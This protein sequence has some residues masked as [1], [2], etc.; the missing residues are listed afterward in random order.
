MKKQ[1]LAL[2]LML[3]ML[4]GM[5]PMHVFAGTAGLQGQS[6]QNTNLA[7]GTVNKSGTADPAVLAAYTADSGS[8]AIA[9]NGTL[10]SGEGWLLQGH[11][12]SG[13]N[14]VG[15]F[16][17]QWNKNHLFLAIKRTSAQDTITLKINGKTVDVSAL[18]ANASVNKAMAE[19]KIPMSQLG[20]GNISGYNTLVALELSLSSGGRYQGNLKL[21][22]V[23]WWKA[24]NVE[25]TFSSAGYGV[26]PMR[27]LDVSEAKKGG[28]VGGK[29]ITNGLQLWDKYNPTS[30]A[31]NQIGT[32]IET[33]ILTASQ[34]S[35]HDQTYYYS[36]DF[37]AD[38][39]PV[40]DLAPSLGG[41]TYSQ[42]FSNFGFSWQ[43]G[44]N[45]TNDS[46]GDSWADVVMGG[47]VNT[48]D[49]LYLNISGDF[50]SALKL[51]KKVGDTFTVGLAWHKNGDVSVY[52]DGVE[53]GYFTGKTRNLKNVVTDGIRFFC[54]RDE[55]NAFDSSDDS[56][57]ISVTSIAIG[58]ALPESPVEALRF[59]DIRN[60]NASAEA[61]TSDLVLPTVLN[62]DSVFGGLNVTWESSHPAVISAS[63][64]VT[65]PASGA[66]KVTLTAKDSVG[67]QKNLDVIVLGNTYSSVRVLVVEGD[68]NPA[69]GSAKKY[70]GGIFHFDSNNNSLVYDQVNA[71]KTNV[72]KL[73]DIDEVSRLNR[74]SISI[75]TSNDNRKYTRLEDNFKLLHSGNSW[76]LYDFEANARYIKVNY[77]LWDTEESDFANVMN[78]A[79]G[80]II[81]AYYEDVFGANYGTFSEKSVTVTNTTTKK[82]QD[83]PWKIAG[84]SLGINDLAKVRVKLSNRYLYHYTDGKD[85]YVRIPDLEKNES[86]TL[87]ILH[88]N[89]GAMDISNK[90]AV[91]EVTYGTKEMYAGDTGN[92]YLYALKAGT[93]LRNGT[94]LTKDVVLYNNGFTFQLSDDGGYTWETS[95]SYKTS[96]FSGDSPHAHGGYIFDNGRLYWRTQ[97]YKGT[98]AGQIII[99]YSDDGGKTWVNPVLLNKPTVGGH[100]FAHLDSYANGVALSSRDGDGPKVDYIFSVGGED[101]NKLWGNVFVI[102]T[103]GGK[104]WKFGNTFLS[105]PSEQGMEGGLTEA[106]LLENESGELVWYCRYQTNKVVTFATS[107]SKDSGLSWTTPTSSTVYGTNTQPVL[108]KI[109][110]DPLFVWGGNNAF[111]GHTFNRMPLS[112]AVSYDGL[113]TFRNIQNAFSKTFLENYTQTE[114]GAFITNPSVAK[115][116]DDLLIAYYTIYPGYKVF[117]RLT[118][119]ENWFY[120]T[121]GAYDSF[122]GQNTKYEGWITYSGG[123][124]I[125]NNASAGKYALEIA[126]NGLV[127]RSI[128]YLQNGTVSLDVYADGQSTF[129]I[130][131]QSAFTPVIRKCAPISLTVKGNALY[132]NGYDIGVKLN[133]GWN[134]IKINLG[135]AKN[136]PTASVCVNNGVTL[137]L[138]ANVAVGDYICYIAVTTGDASLRIDEVLV[139]SS[140][141]AVNYDGEMKDVD[142]KINTQP[143]AQTA[144]EGNK[145]TFSVKATGNGLTYQWYVNEG[146]GWKVIP[147]GTSASY[148]TDVLKTSN[149]GHQY[150]CLVWDRNENSVESSAVSLNV[151]SCSHVANKDDGNCTTDITCSLCGA[152]MTEG[153]KAHTE[154]IVNAKDATTTKKGYTGDKVCSVCG[155]VIEKGK[156]I[157]IL[158]TIPTV[159]N[160]PTTAPGKPSQ[161]GTP[162]TTP[163]ATTDPS[164][165]TTTPGATTDPSSP[166]TTPGAT[167]DP[168]NPTTTPG[169]TTGP[170]NPTANPS[171]P[172]DPSNP[173]NPVDPSSPSEPDAT[174]SP[175]VNDE[176]GAPKQGSIV[177]YIVIGAVALLGAAAG[178]VFYFWKKRSSK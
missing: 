151:K 159:P 74:E 163:G 48:K 133:A 52:I 79:D 118:D 166:T 23:N 31:T 146:S 58:A 112:I 175:D 90:E 26:H 127:S 110:G 56:F 121:K 75:W 36:F 119:F 60:A 50:S 13:D 10:G 117:T 101:Q 176:P 82:L 87:K 39:M 152:V 45:T 15:S 172:T 24:S 94:T 72:I 148:T 43:M 138:N 114:L 139:Q 126:P 44:R 33:T 155:Y 7:A 27:G 63:G 105:L 129:T 109:D 103:D 145:A 59:E 137:S 49:G 170:S 154:K 55:T 91:Y 46:A 47:I 20:L 88:G 149:N 1:F 173:D 111:G 107:V 120:R 12:T 131:L 125:S 102:S 62:K 123:T 115:W 61:V 116:G 96:T 64:K 6:V 177:I 2:F 9:V 40:Y 143:T 57:D 140:L 37:K 167:T 136:T 53:Q 68:I 41:Y 19:L 80:N 70:T 134:N 100:Y 71:S 8:K 25:N 67:N 38:S 35:G 22:S 21:S 84:S 83:Y 86:V 42:F 160:T 66:V 3:V 124:S 28:Y 108:N 165:P 178:I 14:V 153:K 34:M 73:I 169:A 77:T 5:L 171:T 113:Y 161:P 132:A 130:E 97:V 54:Y 142:V 141:D 157:P 168:S 104:T 32:R 144:T 51:N 76:Y 89:S 11:L 98:H 135:L 69:V 150:K 29:T 65:R 174:L 122:E 16:G 162:A 147:G 4:I 81:K 18:G 30:G 93:A 95:G 156:E 106:T 92:R 85:L 128:P 78:N 99:V 17:A 158:G 164:S